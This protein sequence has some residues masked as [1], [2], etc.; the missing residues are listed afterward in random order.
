VD[1]RLKIL[2]TLIPDL[3]T[4]KHCLDVGANAGTVSVQLAFDFDAAS[5]AGVDIDPSL[6]GQAEKL[7]ALRAS[8]RRPPTASSPPVVDY[9]PMSALLTHGYRVEPQAKPA[10]RPRVCFFAADWALPTGQPVQPSYDVILALSVIK[11]IH[12]EHGDPGLVAF[13]AKC[14][15]S[16][17]QGGYLA[18][19][20][21]PWDSYLKAVRPNHAPHFQQSLNQLK[22]R[23]EDSFD[24]LLRDQGL[25]LCASSHQL[26]RRISVYR[27]A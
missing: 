12:L 16:L 19:E 10:H 4:A 18:I 25:H 3:F 26:P 20:L 15:H 17:T 21:Q 23:P 14:S 27:K 6:V 24:Q 5:V 2:N 11:W 9:F 13:F 8:R 7:Y 1:P 22:Y